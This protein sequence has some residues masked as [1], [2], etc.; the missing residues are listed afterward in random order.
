MELDLT[1]TFHLYL[2]KIQGVSLKY[3]SRLVRNLVEKHD[4]VRQHNIRGLFVAE[5]ESIL[6]TTPNTEYE[7]FLQRACSKDD[8]Q[9]HYSIHRTRLILIQHMICCDM[10]M[11]P[12]PTKRSYRRCVRPLDKPGTQAGGAPKSKTRAEWKLERNYKRRGIWE[13]GLKQR[14][15]EWKLRQNRGMYVV[16]LTQRKGNKVLRAETILLIESCER[17]LKEADPGFIPK[18]WPPGIRRWRDVRRGWTGLKLEDL[19]PLMDREDS[20]RAQKR[21]RIDCGVR[22]SL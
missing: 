11:L 22:D 4:Y 7:F 18:Q 2:A 1:N 6:F 19:C 21:R 9:V 13:A 5:N 17:K 3:R 10:Q 14:K 16:D 15:A 20:G 8:L 12:I